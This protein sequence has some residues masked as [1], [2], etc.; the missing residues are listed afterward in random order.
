MFSVVKFFK[1]MLGL[2]QRDT[3]SADTP[4]ITHAR[5]GQPH[6]ASFV[7]INA[8]LILVVVVLVWAGMSSVDEV[9]HS[10]GR[11]IPSAKMQVLQNQEGGI[12]QKINVKQGDLVQSGQVLVNLSPTQFGADFE[13]KKQQVLS[14]MA[15]EARLQAEVEGRELVFT[16]DFSDM[17]KDYVAIE[18]AEF[19]N[20]K[21]RLRADMAV[22]ENQLKNASSELEIIKRLVDRGLEPQLE[23]IRTEARVDEARG[24][25]ESLKRQAKTEASSELAKTAMELNPLRK[26]LPALADRV[27]RTY[28]RAP[29]KGVVN[30]VLV[31]TL[32]GVIKPG[33]AVLELVPS[34]DVLVVEAQVRP[35]DIGFVKIGQSANVKISAYDYSIFGSMSGQVTQISADAVSREERG[36]T[37]YYYIAR[38]ETQTS[39][40]NSLGKK[41]PI[42][43]GMQAQVDIITGN[44]TVLNYLLKP[45]V[46]MKENA[47][48]ER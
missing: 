9:T 12:V 8:I 25:L 27:E 2:S 28:V 4:G 16:P 13:S 15:K 41:L 34:D 26:A 1:R 29:M 11:V 47:F 18:R 33:E 24:K 35:Q 48:R 10:E 45:I 14:L 3:T 46:G 30:R 37:V 44:K 38:I 5:L 43:P 7:L 20:R 21:M 17:A 39:V 40:M 36:Q 23:R 32:G 42:I 31:T 22:I 19:Y 6:K